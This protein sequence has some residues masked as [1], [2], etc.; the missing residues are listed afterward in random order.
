MFTMMRLKV[1]FLRSLLA[2]ALLCIGAGGAHGDIALLV[3]FSNDELAPVATSVANY[4][5][6]DPNVSIP[7]ATVVDVTGN[8]GAAPPAQT[9]AGV[10]ISA[11]LSGMERS[12]T[13]SGGIWGT[14]PILDSY[15]GAR[16][17]TDITV[18]VDSIEEFATGT[19]VTLVVYGVGDVADQDGNINFTYNGVQS[20]DVFTEADA[21]GGVNGDEHAVFNFTKLAGVDSVSFTNV[22]AGSWRGINAFSLTGTAAIPEPSSAIAFAAIAGLCLVRRRRN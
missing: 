8:G 2:I 21:T 12:F 18:G 20:A 1:K 17:G 10:G 19:D 9:V 4:A 16:D 15:V 11:D 6:A 5:A 7:G 3:N 13:Q 14:T 22:G